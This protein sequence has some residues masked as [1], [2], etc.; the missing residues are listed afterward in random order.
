MRKLIALIEYLLGQNRAVKY[1]GVVAAAKDVGFA[2]SIICVLSPSERWREYRLQIEDIDHG[3]HHETA[4]DS[5]ART[6]DN[7]FVRNQRGD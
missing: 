3:C 2:T 7:A 1:S 6:Q 4:E 5:D